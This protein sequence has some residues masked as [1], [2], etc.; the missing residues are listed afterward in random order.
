MSS[1]L[2]LLWLN[3]KQ[4]LFLFNLEMGFTKFLM[5]TELDLNNIVQQ[6]FLYARDG[7]YKRTKPL[8]KI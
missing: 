2:F 1:S 3:K 4:F 8:Y 6:N 5:T 7:V